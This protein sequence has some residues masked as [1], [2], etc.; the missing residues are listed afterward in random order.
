MKAMLFPSI[1]IGICHEKSLQ[2]SALATTNYNCCL[3]AEY[4]AIDQLNSL[5]M[6]TYPAE[7]H[8]LLSSNT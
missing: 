6:Q 3:A 7:C 4:N 1:M 2:L 8:W 5:R